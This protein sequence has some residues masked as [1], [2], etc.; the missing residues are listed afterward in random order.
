MHYLD[1][2]EILVPTGPAGLRLIP[3]GLWSS[4]PALKYRLDFN[5]AEPPGIE[6][7]NPSD[8]FKTE[9]GNRCSDLWRLANPR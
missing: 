2:A 1:G 7:I 6:G 4:L 9:K 3:H 8:D 5:L